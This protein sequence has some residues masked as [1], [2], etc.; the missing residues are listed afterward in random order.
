MYDL[1]AF[2]D[3][4]YQYMMTP[5]VLQPSIVAVGGLN[6]LTGCSMFVVTFDAQ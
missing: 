2:T 4:I 5:L 3:V 1:N 6:M